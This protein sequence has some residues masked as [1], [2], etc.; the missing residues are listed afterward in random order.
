[1][2][3]FFTALLIV[4]FS[5]V[6]AADYICLMGAPG[7]GKGT[8][9]TFLKEHKPYV[10]ICLGDLLREE[11]AQGTPEGLL[12]KALVQNGELVPNEIMFAIFRRRFEANLDKPMIIDGLVQSK[13]NIEFFDQLL[14]EHDLS[15][16]FYFVYLNIPKEV[17]ENRLLKRCV[18]PVCQIPYR[19]SGNCSQCGTPLEKRLDDQEI[20]IKKRIDR[21]FNKSIHL[22]DFYRNRDHFIEFNGENIEGEKWILIN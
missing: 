8:L 21:F 20:T 3:A 1:M 2:R 5:F 19:T 6:G 10:H 16:S 22:I 7:S 12:C 14:A 17:V 4:M 15:D 11:I 9:S 18:C 13:E